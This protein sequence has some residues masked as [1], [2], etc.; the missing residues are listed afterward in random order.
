MKNSAKEKLFDKL[1]AFNLLSENQKH[2]CN[3]ESYLFILIF[4]LKCS[5]C[6]NYLIFVTF[7]SLNQQNTNQ[8]I[9]FT[10]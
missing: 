9:I 6:P 2:Q 5:Y 8:N 10:Y 3:F 7:D 1:F 4:Y